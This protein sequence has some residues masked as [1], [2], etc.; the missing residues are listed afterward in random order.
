VEL[1]ITVTDDI[2]ASAVD[3]IVR[4][5]A[6][7]TMGELASAVRAGEGGREP[8]RFR[9]FA[10][11]EEV[12][13][14]MT[15]DATGLVAGS[16]LGIGGSRPDLTPS[17]PPAGRTI[18][19]T[20]G[21]SAGKVMNLPEGTLTIGRT[22]RCDLVIDDDEVSR[23]HAAI[24][25]T[26]GHAT[27]EDLH[28]SNGTTVNG[29][30][31]DGP[32]PVADGDL[33][34][35]GGSI[36]TVRTEL[37]APAGLEPTGDGRLRFNKPPR[38]MPPAPEASFQV[39]EEP[40]AT[41]PRHFSLVAMLS[42]AVL[43]LLVVAITG[44]PTFLLFSLASPLMFGAN[45][46]SDRRSGRRSYAKRRAGYEKAV[47]SLTAQVDAAVR[48]QQADLRQAS[49]DPAAVTL[50]ATLPGQRLWERRRDDQDFLV[51]RI[52]VGDQPAHIT[53]LARSDSAD[54]P[55]PVNQ[56]VPVT[57]PLRQVGVLGVAG[58]R[59]AGLRLVRSLVLQLATLHAPADLSMVLLTSG[60]TDGWEWIK[61]LPHLAPPTPGDA[62]RSVAITAEQ[63]GT[64]IGELVAL[65]EDRAARRTQPYG[66]D[67]PA[68]PTVL[69]L[70]DDVT[71]LRAEESV[72]FLLRQG[73]AVGVLAICLAEDH[74]GL[75]AETQ[76]TVDFTAAPE[77]G[78]TTIAL[79]MGQGSL[80]G[81]VPDGTSESHATIVARSLAPIFEVGAGSATAGQ[82]PDPPVDHMKLLGL[83]DPT[84]DSALHRWQRSAPYRLPALIGVSD[85]GP[86]ELDLCRDGP[87]AL[88]AG[89]TGAGK[90]ELLQTLVASLALATRPDVLTFL[91]VD[92]KGGSAF[93]DCER[94]PHTLGVISNLDGR[95]IERALDSL[96]AELRWRQARF[97]EAAAKDFDEYQSSSLAGPR[98]IPRLVVVVDE[99]KEL[100]DAYNDAI[101]R[102]NQT[103]RLG[104]S[105][106]VHLILATQKPGLVPG[107]ADLRANT[108]LRVSL[109]VQDESDSRELIGV[110]D[111]ATIRRTQAGRAILRSSDGRL[112]R[113]Q[114]GFLGGRTPLEPAGGRPRIQVAPYELATLGGRPADEAAPR[115]EDDRGASLPVDG[116]TELQRLVGLIRE[117]ADRLHLPKP[118]LPWLPPLP[119]VLTADDPRLA[120]AGGSLSF[121]I[122]LL[123]D[124]HG[125]RQDP[126][127][128]DF[129]DLAHLLV[130]G[131]TR[132]G[133][134][135]LLRTL[136]GIVARR[137]SVSDVHLY[138]FEFRR[139]ALMDLEQLPHCGAVVGVDDTER[140]ERCF[141]FLEAEIERRASLMSGVASLAE[142][143][144]LAPP[145]KALPHVLVLCDNYE[146]FSERFA[147]EDGG[148]LVERFGALLSDGPAQGVHFV[149]TSDRRST[150]GR[151]GMAVEARFF[152]RPTDR[153]DQ[154]ALGLPSG[155]VPAEM[156]PGRGYWYRGPVEGQICLLAASVSG[157]A[158]G[159]AIA[160]TARQARDVPSSGTMRPPQRVPPLPARISLGDVEA[161]R[162]SA[163]PV[164][165]AIVTI[166]VGG[167]DVGP[168]DIDLDKV[169][170]SLVVAG[171]RGSGRSTALLTIA[172][173]LSFEHDSR[174]ALILVAPRRSPLRDL[175]ERPGVTVLTS[176]E[177]LATDLPEALG[178]TQGPVALV[179]DDA[180][181]LLDTT[182][183]N[184][185]DR[186]VRAASDNDWLIIIGGTTTD[187]GRRFSGWIFDARQSRC[188]VLLQPASPADG[189]V[190]DVRLPRSTGTGRPPP[191]GR[192]ILA[193]RGAWTT[194]QV[195]V[196]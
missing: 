91:L 133:R 61:W 176:V 87:H 3:V 160:E 180:E 17:A 6:G 138:A 86:L 2:A 99:L 32:H 36:L 128:L 135:T 98:P 151:L 71:V 28:S 165:R 62:L 92:F 154:L 190:L 145:D 110:P 174:V 97:S 127:V 84:A 35:V 73:P 183:S 125:Q 134:T 108:D 177:T 9:L 22:A 43:G 58:P 54:H 77:A 121:P 175:S 184:R 146:A 72:A 159:A 144:A 63:R 129:E 185:L 152:L 67:R 123:D 106:G 136:A 137:A 188:G 149:V 113:L 16:L 140:M 161:S 117:A 26:A 69:V 42:P 166:G 195:A 104:R 11:R 191:P 163:R 5:D 12:G 15:I 79:T 59:P 40:Q 105:L 150:I 74:S 47:V 46:W 13:S 126:L 153:D 60:I 189:E 57:V 147:Y 27:V 20:G 168:L 141:A 132:S 119:A 83:T 51:A 78:P 19:V 10:G 33:I 169:G 157:E 31:I 41:T 170:S 4:C 101:P 53:L 156:P 25:V 88:V 14:S 100:A 130:V 143:R 39:P 182:A 155:A 139:R 66:T 30:Q 196:P 111:A 94:L 192:G 158:Q 56:S 48:Q 8:E 90:S 96:Q 55:S 38:H 167:I 187:L 37:G 193:L 68:W 75:P 142:Q 172:T 148:R 85:E 24:T 186:L 124:P 50:I 1:P 114:T 164:G 112:V 82:L 89:T 76:A 122:G 102:L 115:L 173:S 95:L 21:L 162:R 93:R 109:R 64:R 116:P 52:G 65:I 29:V 194:V 23:L 44:Q 18:A 179:V 107:L 118:R 45:A 181:M 7:V 70:L 103:A 171:P 49:P 178:S 81:V 34:G 120:A 80:D 131:S